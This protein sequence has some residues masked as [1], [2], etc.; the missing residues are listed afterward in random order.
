MT[1]PILTLAAFR[2]SHRIGDPAT[3]K[4]AY[5]AA[6]NFD[7]G[8]TDRI[9]IYAGD[10]VLIENGTFWAYVFHNCE[11]GTRENCEAYLFF[12]FY[13]SE[14]VET[15]AWS[16]DTLSALLADWCAWR[17]LPLQSADELI[18]TP[19]LTAV[20]T[21]WLNWFLNTWEKL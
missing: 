10:S 14:C 5:A 7:T 9:H 16:V 18:L 11:G 3:D 21:T 17:G 19:G 8:P 13:V 1:D 6:V 20:H 12:E 4:T 2:A 15:A